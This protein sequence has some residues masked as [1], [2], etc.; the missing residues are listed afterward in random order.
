[1]EAALQRIREKIVRLRAEDTDF[2]VFGADGH[3]YRFNPPL[4]LTAIHDFETTHGI[5]LPPGYVA[6]LSQIGN[7]GMGPFYGLEPLE[8]GLFDDLD[9]KNANDFLT[10]SE[11][12]VHVELWN[13]TFTGAESNEDI[14]EKQWLE[15][16]QR[17]YDP[18]R[19]NGSIAICN[20]GCGVNL[21]LV[22]N[23]PEYDHIWTD[24]RCNGNGIYPSYE[25][26]NSEKQDFLGWYEC[27]LDQSLHEVRNREANG[28]HLHNT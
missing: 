19:M 13:E 10:P 18:L 23:G 20:F 17:Y 26:G 25:L 3:Q 11:P 15:F 6:F 1:M 8:N 22:V 9:Y 24:D 28:K 14:A 7:G 12:F 27:W 2:R 5:T 21:H 4:S 16:E